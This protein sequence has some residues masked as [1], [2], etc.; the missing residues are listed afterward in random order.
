MDV[1]TYALDTLA[2][3]GVE[4]F[5]RAAESTGGEFVAYAN[6]SVIFMSSDQD[7]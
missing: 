5:R 4:Y 7:F 6:I 1:C 3:A 2:F